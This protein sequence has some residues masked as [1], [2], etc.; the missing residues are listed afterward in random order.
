MTH[1]AMIGYYYPSPYTLAQLSVHPPTIHPQIPKIAIEP[2]KQ[3]MVE[4][5]DVVER[6]QVH[7]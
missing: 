2:Q 4:M 3:E 5:W 6:C 7:W 1:V